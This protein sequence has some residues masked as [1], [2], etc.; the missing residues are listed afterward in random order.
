M[1]D[2]SCGGWDWERAAT[3]KPPSSH[4][5]CSHK[6]RLTTSAVINIVHRSQCSHKYKRKRRKYYLA[7]FVCKGKEPFPNFI[8]KAGRA[9]SSR[10][11]FGRKGRFLH[12]FS[13]SERGGTPITKTNP[14]KYNLIVSPIAS[15]SLLPLRLDA[16][17]KTKSKRTKVL[18]YANRKSTF[19]V[20]KCAFQ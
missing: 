12:L 2:V 19:V 9:S 1:H 11:V 14:A 3:R 13:N 18:K 8:N 10:L 17:R 20:C 15:I 16:D 5:Q 6:R 4:H 7:Q